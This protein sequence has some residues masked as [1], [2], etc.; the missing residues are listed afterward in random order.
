MK[1]RAGNGALVLAGME[2]LQVR[3]K[4]LLLLASQCVECKAPTDFEHGILGARLCEGCERSFP[5]Y[6][7]IRPEDRQGGQGSRER[8]W[9]MC[10][11]RCL[12]VMR[13]GSVWR[14]LPTPKAYLQNT[15]TH[16]QPPFEQPAQA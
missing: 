16:T 9:G 1:P 15:Y 11:N 10:Q 13:N 2:Q 6:A 8:F 3:R 12:V 5:H 7:L 4:M 14:L